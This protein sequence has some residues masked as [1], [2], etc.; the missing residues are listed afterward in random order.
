MLVAHRDE[1]V[2]MLANGCV[3][4]IVSYEGLASPLAKQLGD[5]ADDEAILR[6]DI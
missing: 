6:D 2:E 1:L 4:R 5:V 3:A